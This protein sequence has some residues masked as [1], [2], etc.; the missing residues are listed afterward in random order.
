M[1]VT[2]GVIAYRRPDGSF[3]PAR[4]IQKEV[5]EEEGARIEAHK[6][7]LLAS[8]FA[9]KYEEHLRKKRREEERQRQWRLERA[10][11]SGGIREI[12]GKKK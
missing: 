5:S 9:K 11:L 6:E 8:V 4:P 7:D 3:L 1:K 10:M 2:I 12:G